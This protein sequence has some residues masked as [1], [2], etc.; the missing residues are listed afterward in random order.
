MSVKNNKLISY[1]NY[2]NNDLTKKELVT[3]LNTLDIKCNKSIKKEE[4]VTLILDEFEDIVA[5]NVSYFTIDEYRKLKKIINKGGLVKLKSDVGMMQF[6]EKL[7]NR[8]LMKKIDNKKFV[9]FK[10]TYNLL[11]KHVKL[12]KTLRKCQKNTDELHLILGST[13]IYGAINLRR[14]YRIYTEKYEIS[15]D[16]LKSY[17]IDLA[18]YSDSF[19]VYQSKTDTYIASKLIKS[20]NQCKKYAEALDIKEYTYDEVQKIYTL[21]YFKDYKGYC[22]L[23]KFITE[24]YYIEKDNFKVIVES[25]INPFIEEYQLNEKKANDH[26][27]RAID[28][29]FEF[30]SNRHKDRFITLISELIKDYPSWKLNGYSEREKKK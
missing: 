8:Y 4:M 7:T 24:S 13:L 2:L 10:E 26:L 11:K 27:E 23:K 1:E 5:K 21:Q 19:I 28:D 15:E 16:N 25:I 30:N 14:F 29:Y 3:L 12:K 6:C 17:L 20:I 22:K 18:K 9:L